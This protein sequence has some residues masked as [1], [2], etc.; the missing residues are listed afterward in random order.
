MRQR[1][2]R[3]RVAVVAVVACGLAAGCTVAGAP[4]AAG[5]RG[6]RSPAGAPFVYVTGKGKTNEI[7]QFASLGS[8]APRPDSPAALRWRSGQHPSEPSN[9]VYRQYHAYSLCIT[10]N[11][12]APFWPEP[13]AV[14]H[15][16]F[17]P[18]YAYVITS[19][20]GSG[21]RQGLGG[22]H[23][24]TAPRWR[25]RVAVRRSA[26]EKAALATGQAGRLHRRQHGQSPVPVRPGGGTVRSPSSSGLRV[27]AVRRRS[28]RAGRGHL[29]RQER[30]P[31]R[32]E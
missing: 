1:S 4:A 12:G 17:D 25:S 3:P 30:N 6:G 14:A 16:V 18:P 22:R 29:V 24:G 31:A 21:A 10:P 19:S 2:A 28:R 13:D 7:S 11:H 9:P 27:R 5:P 23:C 32:Q 26:D 15:G 20:P 8:G